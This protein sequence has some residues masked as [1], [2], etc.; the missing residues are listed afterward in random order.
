M[1]IQKTSQKYLITKILSTTIVGSQWHIS[2]TKRSNIFLEINNFVGQP[3]NRMILTCMTE[4]GFFFILQAFIQLQSQISLIGE[5]NEELSF[6]PGPFGGLT[7][8]NQLG[9]D[10]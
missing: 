2:K 5:D 7:V 3:K 8:V 1:F 9:Q 6:G 10:E 4:R